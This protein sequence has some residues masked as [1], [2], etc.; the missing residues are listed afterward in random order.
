MV[1]PAATKLVMRGRQVCFVIAA[2]KGFE[3]FGFM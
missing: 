1:I 3:A 2:K